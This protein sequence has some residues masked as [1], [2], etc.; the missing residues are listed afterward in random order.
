MTGSHFDQTDLVRPNV[1]G[2]DLQDSDVTNQ[3]NV[4][5]NI[6]SSV[7]MPIESF[8]ISAV[9]R[10]TENFAENKDGK[11][12]LQNDENNDN[13]KSSS[14]ESVNNN[15]A[16]ISTTKLS[17]DI[18]DLQKLVGDL[19]NLVTNEPT[20]PGQ[21]LPT[22]KSGRTMIEASNLVTRT[23][24]TTRDQYH[25]TNFAVTDSFEK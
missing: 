13:L 19:K 16:I 8:N 20:S 4:Q 3:T 23:V 11:N 10:P 14:N 2:N 22:D 1:G 15:T 5:Y 21:A 18:N 12:F 24:Q 7:K 17:E 9:A 6:S 25:I